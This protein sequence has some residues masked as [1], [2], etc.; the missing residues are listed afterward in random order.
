MHDE[1]GDLHGLDSAQILPLVITAI[2]HD[3]FAPHMPYH[4]DASPRVPF[5]HPNAPNAQS[6]NNSHPPQQGLRPLHQRPHQPSQLR[7]GRV[8]ALASAYGDTYRGA[9][10]SSKRKQALGWGALAALVII[11]AAVVLP[12]YFLVIK[13]H[14]DKAATK[15]TEGA[16]QNDKGTDDGAKPVN[17]LL[18]G[19][20]WST[21]MKADG[22]S[23]CVRLGGIVRVSLS[24]FFCPCP[25]TLVM[26]YT[27]LS[28]PLPL[29]LRLRPS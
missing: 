16:A 14:N 28:T 27:S 24:L 21:V 8:P 3:H 29:A 5:S 2:E 10:T 9:G 4:N 26:I 6:I 7:L 23:F 20:D 12:V 18:M 25:D 22:S 17:A 19:A 1:N 13:T 11:A 15:Y